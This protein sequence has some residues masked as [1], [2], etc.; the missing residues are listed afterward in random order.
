MDGS[1]TV[2]A[3]SAAMGWIIR[4]QLAQGV[5]AVLETNTLIL[6]HSCDESVRLPFS[7]TWE[8]DER[9]VTALMGMN[10]GKF[11]ESIHVFEGGELI[12]AWQGGSA[13][14]LRPA[15][16]SMDWEW[17]ITSEQ[18]PDKASFSVV[19]VH[20]ETIWTRYPVGLDRVVR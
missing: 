11:V 16:Y 18:G 19:S 2:S 3:E 13:L 8:S 20:G 17:T 14:R 7:E 6:E 9:Q 4:F 1:Q 10:P 15:D 12:I 5:A